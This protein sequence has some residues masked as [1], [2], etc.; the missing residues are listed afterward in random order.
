MPKLV[1]KDCVIEVNDVDLSARASRVTITSSKALV[2]STSFGARYRQSEVGLGDGNIAIT[3]QQ[4]YDAAS[5]DATLWPIHEADD[6]CRVRVK[7][8]SAATGETNPAYY[9]DD[10]VLPDYTPLNGSVGDLST[11]D[12]TFQNAGQRGITR[13]IVDP[14]P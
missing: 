10:A 11:V 8:T 4:D 13:E 5:V 14:T 12:V 2:D 6:H 9:M 3:F 7:P 1:L